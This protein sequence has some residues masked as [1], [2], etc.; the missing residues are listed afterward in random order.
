LSLKLKS[1]GVSQGDSVLRTRH[2]HRI[3]PSRW[4]AIGDDIPVLQKTVAVRKSIGDRLDDV[5]LAE[6][7]SHEEQASRIGISRT[8]Y[9]QVKAGRG[10]KRSKGKVMNYLNPFESAV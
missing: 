3:A 6:N 2:P 4:F 8:A 5:A 7:I 9:F 1:P 10:G